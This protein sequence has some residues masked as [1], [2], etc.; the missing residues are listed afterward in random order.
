MAVRSAAAQGAPAAVAK[1]L[2]AELWAMIVDAKA[3]T[4]HGRRNHSH[5][6]SSSSCS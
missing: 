3:S 4:D 1:A 5:A 6:P 2:Y